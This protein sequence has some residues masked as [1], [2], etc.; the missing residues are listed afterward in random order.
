MVQAFI[1]IL[2]DSCNA[3]YYII[4]DAHTVGP[5]CRC[6][7]ADNRWCDHIS[8][9]LHQLHWTPV[10]QHVNFKITMLVYCPCPELS[11]Q[12]KFAA[13]TRVRQL[14]S[15]DNGTLVSR[16]CSSFHDKTF[17]TEHFRRSLKTFYSYLLT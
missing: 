7:V 8:L 13:D 2:L 15:A 9:I 6:Q 3:L 4:S 11:G 12:Q 14:H 5:E 16:T 10:L 17:A 1:T